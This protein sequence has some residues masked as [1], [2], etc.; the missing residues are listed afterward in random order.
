MNLF[1]FILAS[2]G[3]TM[4][5]AYGKI[6]DSIRP[7]HHYFHCTMCLGFLV[8]VFN[9]FMLDLPF[10]LFLSGCISSGTSYLLSKLVD[11]DGITI[12]VN[13]HD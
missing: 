3:L 5:L 1:I 2:Y 6:F 13:K 10:N 12:K 7:K 9:S 4:I 8:G 11:D